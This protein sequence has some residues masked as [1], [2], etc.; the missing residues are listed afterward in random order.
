MGYHSIA[1]P[2]RGAYM[3]VNSAVHMSG[4]EWGLASLNIVSLIG[5]ANVES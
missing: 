1:K 3:Y 2:E 5:L 4:L